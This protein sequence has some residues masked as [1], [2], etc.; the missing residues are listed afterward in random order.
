VYSDPFEA[1]LAKVR[2]RFAS[3]LETKIKDTV[4]A[5]PNLTASAPGA[6]VT[7]DEVYRRIH[8]ICGVGPTVG[9]PAT[10]KAAREAEVILLVPMRDKRGLNPDE[11]AILRKAVDGLWKAAHAELQAMYQRGG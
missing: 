5:L 10:G 8:T 2:H 6:A 4:T 1:R 3:S 7:V 11:S 9:F